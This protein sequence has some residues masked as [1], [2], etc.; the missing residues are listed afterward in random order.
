MNRLFHQLGRDGHLTFR[1]KWRDLVVQIFGHEKLYDNQK[2]LSDVGFCPSCELDYYRLSVYEFKDLAWRK[3]VNPFKWVEFLI[4]V[5]LEFLAWG[6]GRLLG[7]TSDYSKHLKYS[8]Q[9]IAPGKKLFLILAMVFLTLSNFFVN[10][11][12]NLI[13][14]L[15]RRVLAPARY[16]IRPS[17]ELAKR[18][19][20]SFLAVLALT[21]GLA[22]FVAVSIFTGGLPLVA[23]G[24]IFF[25]SLGA[26]ILL[27][28]IASIAIWATLLK[29]AQVVRDLGKGI[30]KLRR[31]GSERKDHVARVDRMNG[32]AYYMLSTVCFDKE[33]QLAEL[34]AQYRQHIPLLIKWE[35]RIWIYGNAP[36]NKT[37]LT[38]IQS[39]ELDVEFSSGFITQYTNVSRN[40]YSEIAL[41]RGHF[42][43]RTQGTTD[44]V[45]RVLHG[46][47]PKVM[48]LRSIE[49]QDACYSFAL[50]VGFEALYGSKERFKPAIESGGTAAPSNVSKPPPAF[51]FI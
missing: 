13:T 31:K 7:R 14:G 40:D 27:T 30:Q 34:N 25:A 26:K 50:F 46:L 49:Q 16:I 8:G 24:G 42:V 21:L 10:L 35:N 29:S 11:A 47:N 28:G 4:A 44:K 1:K 32:Q 2:H 48:P 33:P 39:P 3:L 18:R 37:Q 23:V 9:K 17:I 45:S 19:P 41:S 36:K 20:K 5:P 51:D 6:F 12:V 15:M 38:E 43:P 22:A